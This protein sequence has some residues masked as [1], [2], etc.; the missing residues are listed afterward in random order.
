MRQKSTFKIAIIGKESVYTDKVHSI[1]QKE[2]GFANFQI[3]NSSEALKAIASTYHDAFCMVFEEWG[4][5]QVRLVLEIREQFPNKKLLILTHHV[6]LKLRTAISNYANTYILDLE[7]EVL[8]APGFLLRLLEGKEVSYRNVERYRASHFASVQTDLE[9]AMC[10]IKD[11]SKVGASLQGKL[12]HIAIGD[13]VRMEMPVPNSSRKYVL[14]CKVIWLEQQ[15]SKFAFET[16][17]YICGLRFENS[18]AVS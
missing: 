10:H 9:Q 17:F 4:N 18:A 13:S 12:K 16:D 14:N 11:M 7:K 3:N 15:K 5:A 2:I 1:F 8:S 6:G